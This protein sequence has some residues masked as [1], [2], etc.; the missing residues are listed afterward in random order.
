M[1]SWIALFLPPLQNQHPIQ[2]QILPTLKIIPPY[3]VISLVHIIIVSHLDY[4]NS[5]L[6]HPYF[7]PAILHC[8]LITAAIAMLISKKSGHSSCAEEVASFV[9][10]NKSSDLALLYRH[11]MI[12]LLL[13]L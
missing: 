1:S 2:H 8:I 12:W 11:S 7:S 13:T 4:C 6:P 9:T 3:F 5:L 10:Q